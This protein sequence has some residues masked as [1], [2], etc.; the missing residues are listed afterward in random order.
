MLAEI[1]AKKLKANTQTVVKD[2]PGVKTTKPDAR[3]VLILSRTWKGVYNW[4][5]SDVKCVLFT[6]RSVKS[7][8]DMLDQKSYEHVEVFDNLDCGLVELKAVEFHQRYNFTAVRTEN[9]T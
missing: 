9:F 1:Q 6:T 3:P 5:S 2:A 8:F 7:K 4:V